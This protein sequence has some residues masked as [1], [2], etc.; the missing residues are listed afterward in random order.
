MKT[1]FFRVSGGIAIIIAITV[2]FLACP[3]NESEI[4]RGKVNSIIVLNNQVEIPPAD[5]GNLGFTITEGRSVVLTARLMPL[6]VPAGIHWQTARRIVDFSEYSGTETVMFA[7]YGGK[8]IVTIRAKNAYNEMPIFKEINI[9]V[10]PSSYYKWSYQK[11]GWRDIPP[12]SA[13]TVDEIYNRMILYAGTS[14]VYEDSDL[15]GFVL[16]GPATLVIGSTMATPTNS[17]YDEDPLFDQ[18]SQLNF[19]VSPNGAVFAGAVYPSRLS[20]AFPHPDTGVTNGNH[21][22]PLAG[23]LINDDLYTGKVRISVDYQILTEPA[24]RQGLRIQ[25]SN[26]TTER[27]MASVLSNW[28]VAEYTSDHP[29][30]GTLTGIFNSN[31]TRIAPHINQEQLLGLPAIE[32]EIRSEPTESNPQGTQQYPGDSDKTI[33][34]K[35]LRMIKSRVFVCLALPDGKALIRSIRIE[36]AD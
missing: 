31:E 3:A 4:V 19:A 25:V 8:T 6:G 13:R 32:L 33:N 29:S 27:D 18:N 34:D 20:T 7:E 35:K 1:K 30:S 24:R 23:L 9:T 17:P 12:L 11:D 36:A 22:H 15:G 28:L 21:P 10:T 26:N 16:E 5:G 14:A 2:F